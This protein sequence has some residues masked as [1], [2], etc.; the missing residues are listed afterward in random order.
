VVPTEYQMKLWEIYG[1]PDRSLLETSHCSFYFSR[2]GVIDDI[3]K[4]VRHCIA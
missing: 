4:Y 1:K 3:A 2:G